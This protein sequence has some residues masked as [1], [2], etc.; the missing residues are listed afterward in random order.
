MELGEG[1]EF[2]VYPNPARNQATVSFSTRLLYSE[3]N[4]ELRDLT[5]R[6]LWSDLQLAVSPGRHQIDLP[7]AQWSAGTY[8]VSV[9]LDGRRFSK[10]LVIQ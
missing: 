7:T 4:V 6:K 1:V 2:E 9:I 10:Q 8:L 3:M 5:G